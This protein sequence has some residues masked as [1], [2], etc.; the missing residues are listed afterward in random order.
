MKEALYKGIYPGWEE[1]RGLD[2]KGKQ[3]QP[4]PLLDKN[5]VLVKSTSDRA[6]SALGRHFLVAFYDELKHVDLHNT[7]SIVWP[8]ALTCKLQLTH[9]CLAVWCWHHAYCGPGTMDSSSLQCCCYLSQRCQEAQCPYYQPGRRYLGQAEH[10]VWCNMLCFSVLHI[11]MHS[12]AL[13]CTLV[14]CCVLPCT[15]IYSH[16]HLC[17]VVY[18]CVLWC[19]KYMRVHNSAQVLYTLL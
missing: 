3:R 8:C 10:Q 17:I 1:V 2:N 6:A 16:V 11:V 15:V 12:C 9:F 4:H 19:R 14:Y 18:C 7:V 13:L 5:G